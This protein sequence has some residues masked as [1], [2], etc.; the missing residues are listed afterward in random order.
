MPLHVS[1]IFW[2]QFCPQWATVS[3]WVLV[4]LLWNITGFGL[5]A[6]S[7]NPLELL[8]T[9]CV[10]C[11]GGAS[12]KGGLDLTTREALLRGGESGA[13]VVPGDPDSSLLLQTIRHEHEPFMPYKEDK[14]SAV[15]IGQLAA[16]IKSGAVY[17]RPLD[18]TSGQRKSDGGFVLT[19][20]DRAHWAF[21]PIAR[22][23]PPAVPQQAS[24]CENPI[25]QFI[26]DKLMSVGLSQRPVASR[27][28]FIRRVTFDLIGLPP[29]PAEIDDF[30]N[31]PSP[32]ADEELIDRLLASP[33][34]GERWG[35][36]WLD[37][38]RYAES[39]GFEHD[40][41]RPHAWR[42]RDYVIQSLNDDKPYDR[43]I[44]EQI[45]G[46]ELW[47]DDAEAITATGFHLLGPD[48]VDSSDQ[49]QRRH[50]TLNDM[51]DT[52][53]LV[54]LGLTFGCA[55]CHDHKFEPVTQRD[56]YG[57]Q[58]FFT[59]S[60]FN[61][62]KSIATSAQRERYAVALREYNSH[63][64]LQEL[65]A[66]E[67]A[68]RQKL[69]EQKV[70]RLPAEAQAA[71]LTPPE[72]RTAE[73]SNLVLETVAKVMVSDKEITST[74]TAEEKQRQTEIRKEIEKL[75]KPPA[76]PVAMAIES[77]EGSKIKTFL[78][79]RGDYNQPGDEVPPSFPQVLT[80]RSP[81]GSKTPKDGA[82]S[83]RVDETDRADN[84]LRR[85]NRVD[86]A[87]WIASPENPLTARVMVNRI[88]QHH[89]GQALVSTP[90]DFGTHGQAASHPSLLDWLASDFISR[91]WSIKR[92]HRRML[93][94]ATYRQVSALER[95][96]Y[97][98][99]ATASDP[100]STG[101]NQVATWAKG[102]QLDPENRLYW[103][104]NR[105]RLEGEVIRDSLLAISGQLNSSMNGP[106]VS[107]PIPKELFAGAH[108]WSVSEPK[109]QHFRRSIFIFARRNLRFPFLEV[110]DAPDNNLSCAMRERS[111][112]APQ[113][114]T[115]LNSTEVTA[116]AKVTASRL[117]SESTSLEQQIESAYRLALGRVPT[118]NER[119]M[120]EKYL[121]DSPLD[122]FCRALF[123]LNGFVY[124]E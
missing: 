121:I 15:V 120:I 37:L 119:I 52:T 122:E 85:M 62:E 114:L 83:A 51:T 32:C 91:G 84:S 98:H 17:S 64:T 8:E 70:A 1:S 21:Q 101:N 106:G 65:T 110:F 38:A 50:N 61:T 23:Q 87:N 108:G 25:D 86:L 33:H 104:M 30:V 92:M 56:Y 99:D 47:P 118:S 78:L 67:A 68:A 58:A 115:L 59:Q 16:W 12:T 3:T 41:I 11:H 96:R 73:Q 113:S 82:A 90:S 57:F 2:R 27:T 88:W 66:F 28:V 81:L 46:D 54:F 102:S 63:P 40:A 6:E 48:M 60:K 76:P 69:F 49:I 117:K 5:A 20:A 34:Y 36:H 7:S 22:V 72:Q 35:R 100:S 45:A 71:H 26:L 77:V 43:F 95:N 124:V 42:Y 74:L 10:R 116:A 123:N 31:N 97:A 94:A 80:E 93:T 55:R 19:D 89:F 29:T 44:R 111:T 75:R 112:T 109:S 107:P 13:T 105:I 4:T 9:Q 79:H 53:A 24:L 103:R 14:L 18:K 39:D